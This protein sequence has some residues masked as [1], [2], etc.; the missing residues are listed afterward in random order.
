MSNLELSSVR[1]SIGDFLHLT[2]LWTGL[3]GIAFIK[4]IYVGRP[5]PLWEAQFFRHRFLNSRNGEAEL[6]T[7][8]NVSGLVYPHFSLLLTR[9]M[10]P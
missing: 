8:K 5:S 6:R 7:I 2:G 4:I 1:L 3:K 9:D 10:M